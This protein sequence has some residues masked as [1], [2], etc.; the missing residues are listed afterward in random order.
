MRDGGARGAKNEL[1]G[2]AAIAAARGRAEGRT[3]RHW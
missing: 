3:T 1:A 2:L